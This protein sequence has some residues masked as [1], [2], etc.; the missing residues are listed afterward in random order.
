MVYS[1]AHSSPK[2]QAP[3]HRPSTEDAILSS[4]ALREVWIHFDQLDGRHDREHGILARIIAQPGF[5]AVLA[6][7]RSL[8][9]NALAKQLQ[10]DL[11]IS[12]NKLQDACPTSIHDLRQRMVYKDKTTAESEPSN[13][14]LSAEEKKQAAEKNYAANTRDYLMQ[15][16]TAVQ[17]LADFLEGRPPSDANAPLIQ[18][19]KQQEQRLARLLVAIEYDGQQALAKAA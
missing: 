3:E 12:Y 2:A 9:S 4:P 6:E 1:E 5:Q 10:A 16:M 18:L 17:N 19:F 13:N 14:E 11:A 7:M 15:V 8:P